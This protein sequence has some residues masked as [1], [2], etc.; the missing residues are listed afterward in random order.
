[1]IN[2]K[3]E[4]YGD[5]GL[6]QM[7]RKELGAE[8]NRRFLTRMPAFRLEGDV[9]DQLR[10]LLQQLDQAEDDSRRIRRG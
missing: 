2:T 1:M 4:K 8:T 9:P 6:P 7:I 10:A 3:M 5:R